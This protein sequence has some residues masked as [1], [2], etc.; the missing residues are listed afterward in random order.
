MTITDIIDEIRW[1]I[2]DN[3]MILGAGAVVFVIVFIVALNLLSPPQAIAITNSSTPTPIVNGSSPIINGSK[4]TSTPA[5][6]SIPCPTPTFQ[7]PL[8]QQAYLNWVNS[9]KNGSLPQSPGYIEGHPETA[10]GYLIYTA[11]SPTPTPTPVID[12]FANYTH[13]PLRDGEYLPPNEYNAVN[14]NES[15]FWNMYK[16]SG[17]EDYYH[18]DVGYCDEPMFRIE[19]LSRYL[20]EV[21]DPY[22]KI[23]IEKFYLD[24]ATYNVTWYSVFTVPLAWYENVTIPKPYWNYDHTVFHYSNVTI[25]KKL[26]GALLMYLSDG[27]YRFHIEIYD[28][29]Q[30]VRLGEV[31]K[32]ICIF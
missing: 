8:S 9:T 27:T 19:F 11:P 28:H 6:T 15:L 3:I 1:K 12:P 16:T 10:H 31:T 14:G 25:Q 30:T 2:E 13:L 21:K 26:P 20:D 29:A 24:P 23:T 7:D 32:Q 17:L 22:I 4:P 18:N 5:P